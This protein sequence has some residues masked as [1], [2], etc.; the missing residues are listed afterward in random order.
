MN[1]KLTVKQ[2]RRIIKEEASRSLRESARTSYKVYIWSTD[3]NELDEE[4]GVYP[5]LKAAIDARNAAFDEQLAANGEDMS[6]FLSEKGLKGN[7][8]VLEDGHLEYWVKKVSGS[9]GNLQVKFGPAGLTEEDVDVYEDV[10]GILNKP[11]T[12]LEVSKAEY[13]QSQLAALGFVE[14][15]REAP[16]TNY[17]VTLVRGTLDGESVVAVINIFGNRKGELYR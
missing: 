1:M 10:A 11:I 5:S 3:E 8:N 15:E 7:E 14:Q 16:T 4:I 13:S 6:E 9:A 12:S 2:L 17:P